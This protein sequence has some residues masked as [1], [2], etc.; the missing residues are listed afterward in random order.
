MLEQVTR[1]GAGAATYSGLFRVV[2]IEQ[3]IME[4]RGETFKG[5]YYYSVDAL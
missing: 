3:R 1:A 2:A 5:E 4:S